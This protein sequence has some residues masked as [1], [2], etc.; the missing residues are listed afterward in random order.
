MKAQSWPS[1]K[2][3]RNVVCS[4]ARPLAITNCLNFASPERPE[5]MWA[6]SET[7]DGMAEACRELGTPVTGGN[8][9]FYNETEGHGI[10][11]TPVIGMIGLI[12]DARHTTTQWFKD[13]GDVI[14]LL[15][16]TRNDL[17]AS[18]FLSV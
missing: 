18:E 12:E 16:K 7:I 5:V 17:G 4:G 13:E 6:F 14:L 9:S 15:G 3:A 11:P 10:Y 2:P 8:V 1:P